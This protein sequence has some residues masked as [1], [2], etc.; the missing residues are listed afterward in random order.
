MTAGHALHLAEEDGTNRFRAERDDDVLGRLVGLLAASRKYS[1]R[2]FGVLA[3]AARLCQ[4]VTA[5]AST[6]E[7]ARIP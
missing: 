6:A 5:R 2:N 1:H 7:T 4:A 3:L